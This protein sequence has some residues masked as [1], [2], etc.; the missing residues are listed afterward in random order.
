M[1]PKLGETA[2]GAGEVAVHGG[3]AQ[4]VK[5][6]DGLVVG[7]VGEAGGAAVERRVDR[8]CFAAQAGQ[9]ELAG[10]ETVKRGDLAGERAERRGLHVA[11]MHLL[12]QV[13]V[14]LLQVLVVAAQL[15][16]ARGLDEHARVG[17]GKTGDRKQADGRGGEEDPCVT[18][19]N[20]NLLQGSVFLAADEQDVIALLRD[21]TGTFGERS[22]LRDVR[23]HSSL[24]D[25][26][27]IGGDSVQGNRIAEVKC[28][29]GN[30][31]CVHDWTGN[32]RRVPK[33]TGAKQPFGTDSA[34]A[35]V[36]L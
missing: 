34:K 6:V 8:S 33:F 11:L 1:W 15:V 9:G 18:E 7:L 36:Y 12:F 13:R 23:S 32:I 28:G 30:L 10:G 25:E 35:C 27:V 26:F 5:G 3:I 17:A 31:I 19:R 22:R 14:I 24:W 21:Q 29:L 4:G 20:R 2:R 16:E